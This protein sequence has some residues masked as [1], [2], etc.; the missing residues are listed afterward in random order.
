MITVNTWNDVPLTV[1]DSLGN[2]IDLSPLY[3]KFRELEEQLK[4]K[5]E[6]CLSKKDSN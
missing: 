6:E 4:R 2:R 3:Y 5:S 1:Y